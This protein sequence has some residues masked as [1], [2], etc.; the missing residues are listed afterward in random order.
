MKTINDLLLT[1]SN[2]EEVKENSLNLEETENGWIH[3]INITSR[4]TG[5]TTRLVDEAIQH[6]FT[7]GRLQLSHTHLLLSDFADEN[8]FK[9][10]IFQVNF[11]DKIISRL[12][13]EHRHSVVINK[14]KIL[15]TIVITI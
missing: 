3:N 12:E 4:R 9:N 15:T 8:A 7:K 6:L 11:I 10:T 14:S 2:T 13:F 5:K 1:I